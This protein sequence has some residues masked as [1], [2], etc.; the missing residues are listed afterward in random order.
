MCRPSGAAV[1][2]RPLNPFSLTTTLDLAIPET[3]PVTVALYDVLGR[4][5]TVLIDDVRTA[6]L[7]RAILDAA[8]LP[9]GVDRVRMAAGGI[10]ATQ[11]VTVLR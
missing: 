3:G 10:A 11:R 7:H 9:S 6:G 5:V 1:C 2:R 4:L 8:S